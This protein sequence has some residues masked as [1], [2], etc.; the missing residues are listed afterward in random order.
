MNY[1]FDVYVFIRRRRGRFRDGGAASR[2]RRA[3]I[4]CF[5]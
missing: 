2:R 4:M 5:R 3:L 1:V